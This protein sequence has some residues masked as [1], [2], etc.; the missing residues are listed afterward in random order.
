MNVYDEN[1]NPLA[2]WDP[3]LGW[4]ETARRTVRHEAV[5]AAPE[6]GHWETL[7]EYE[8]GGRDVRWVV[9]VPGVTGH[10]AWDEEVE[11]LV[12]HPYTAEELAER[13]RR[14][15]L[16][17]TP[18]ELL[19]ALAELAALLAGASQRLDEQDAALIELAG[20]IAG[21]DA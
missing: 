19:E 17:T 11:Y 2:S 9:D 21:G 18:E 3:A 4:L 20:L 16:Q 12:Y 14:E 13:A 1:G 6:Q 10:D 5:E 15:A 7:R 8:N